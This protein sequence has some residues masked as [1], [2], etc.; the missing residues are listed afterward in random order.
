MSVK[1]IGVNT[2]A[3]ELR[4]TMADLGDRAI[5][6]LANKVTVEAKKNVPVLSSYGRENRNA[7]GEELRHGAG[8]FREVINTTDL[9][10]NLLVKLLCVLALDARKENNANNIIQTKVAIKIIRV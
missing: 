8:I 3:P 6:L 10:E 1:V 2:I 7:T 5:F 9:D 4:K